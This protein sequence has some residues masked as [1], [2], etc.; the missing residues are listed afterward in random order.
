MPRK[1]T[2]SKKVAEYAFERTD[3]ETRLEVLKLRDQRKWSFQ[4]IADK[5]GLKRQRVHQIYEKI[6]VM[7]IAEA[8]LIVSKLQE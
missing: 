7:S 3:W 5:L 4:K 6:S 1:Y 2:I 8:E